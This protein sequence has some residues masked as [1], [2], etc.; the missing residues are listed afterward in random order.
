M[1]NLTHFTHFTLTA[2]LDLG[3]FRYLV[4]L[5]LL[6]LYV[7]TLTSNLLLISVIILNRTLAEPMYLFLCSLFLS[8]LY[9]STMLFPMLL[10][11]VLQQLHQISVSF[12]FLQIYCLHSYATTEYLNLAVLAYDRYI[13]ICFPLQYHSHMSRDR[14]MKLIMSTWLYGLLGVVQTLCIT[15]SLKLCN[16]VISKVYCDNYS[17]VRLACSDVS[18]INIHGLTWTFVTIV[19]P[20]IF[21][22][23]TYL[24]ILRVCFSGSKSV[25]QK[26]LSTC[27]PH[28][29]TLTNFTIGGSFELVQSRFNM[30][31]VPVA[32]RVFLSLYCISSQPLISPLI[33]GFKI[34]KLRSLCKGLLIARLHGI[35]Q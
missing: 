31:G 9:G 32:L 30:N 19:T 21:T 22:M 27:L 18:I 25:R 12:C 24:C 5:V 1:S 13:A 20:F 34:S 4:F 6:V 10:R 23:Y 2:Y 28:L 29:V 17:V 16:N 14:I 33:Y 15:T 8:E 7:L 11:H 35:D 26:A 3:M